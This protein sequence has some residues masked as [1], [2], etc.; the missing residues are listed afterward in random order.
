MIPGARDIHD[1]AVKS[2]KPKLPKFS[3]SRAKTCHQK[4]TASGNPALR[5]EVSPF[6]LSRVS[7]LTT[8]LSLYP[9]ELD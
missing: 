2:Q 1:L 8:F 4:G 5:R 9:A 7:S 3:A 6:L